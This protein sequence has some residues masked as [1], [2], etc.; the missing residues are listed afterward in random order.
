MKCLT[1]STFNNTSLL[2]KHL[3]S[4]N[5]LLW[6]GGR[7]EE[8]FRECCRSWCGIILRLRWEGKAE[9]KEG[10]EGSASACVL[11][12]RAVQRSQRWSGSAFCKQQKLQSTQQRVKYFLR[13]D[14]TCLWHWEPHVWLIEMVD[15]ME[16]GGENSEV[17]FC[18]FPFI[19]APKYCT[20]DKSQGLFVK[21]NLLGEMQYLRPKTL[22]LPQKFWLYCFYRDQREALAPP[23]SY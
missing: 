7:V 5:L 12:A 19:V 20:F 10:G 1:C 15:C 14:F 11:H 8:Q 17:G 6:C 3:S 22:I 13:N 23:F 18:L 9:G 16:F 2:L 21:R 4:D